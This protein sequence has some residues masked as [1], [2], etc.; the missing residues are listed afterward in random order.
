MP[1]HLGCG[2]ESYMQWLCLPSLHQRIILVT[3]TL[4]TVHLRVQFLGL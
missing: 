2:Q 4:V 3:M 1:L